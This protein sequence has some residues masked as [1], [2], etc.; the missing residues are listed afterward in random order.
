MILFWLE[1]DFH[2]RCCL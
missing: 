1:Q 2:W